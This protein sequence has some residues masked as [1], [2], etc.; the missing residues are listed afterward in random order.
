MAAGKAPAKSGLM[1]KYGANLDKAVQENANNEP[2][3]GFIQIPGGIS[4]GIARLT[5]VKFDQYKKGDYEGDWYL[6]MTGV[7]RQPKHITKDGSE[8]KVGGLQTSVMC[9]VCATK[10]SDGKVVSQSEN[11]AEIINHFLILGASTAGATGADLEAIAAA[12]DATCQPGQ[13]HIFFR[14]STSEGK[15]QIDPLTKKPKLDPKT[16][17]PYKPRIWENWHGIKGIEYYVDEDDAAAGVQEDVTTADGGTTE[18]AEE[19]ASDEA[20]AEGEAGEAFVP[21]EDMAELVEC[22]NSGDDAISGPSQ[23]V[24]REKG[25]A[26]GM[27]QEEVDGTD[28]WQALADLIAE[29]EAK[30]DAPDEP[31][32]PAKGEMVFYKPIDPK[33]KKP[34]KKSVQYTVHSV[35]TKAETVTLASMDG[36]VVNGAD[37]KP[38]KVKFTDLLSE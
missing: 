5:S 26:L 35:D 33:T 6:R 16:G 23:D 11:I 14:F 9:P 29:K 12:L 19:P 36:K 2:D 13:Q 7:V 8:V 15:P 30:G 31:A 4:N 37:K 18:P 34:V 38:L 3:Y 28:S 21:P 20:G 1:A 25:M 22:C 10:K 27:T 32:P 24:I 17:E